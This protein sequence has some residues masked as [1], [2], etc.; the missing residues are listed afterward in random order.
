MCQYIHHF[1]RWEQQF[2]HWVGPSGIIFTFMLCMNIPQSMTSTHEKSIASGSWKYNHDTDPNKIH[3]PSLSS[4]PLPFPF[5]LPPPMKNLVCSQVENAGTGMCDDMGRSYSLKVHAFKG[6]GGW[7]G[8][9]IT[10][11]PTEN[12]TIKSTGLLC[13]SPTHEFIWREKWSHFTVTARRVYYHANPPNTWVLLHLWIL[14]HYTTIVASP[15]YL[16]TLT[17]IFC[18]NKFNHLPNR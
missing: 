17:T 7:G 2:L 12:A 1:V 10:K 5:P 15:T 9:C 6:K 13:T 16:I 8:T 3:N 4:L 11:S 14:F 18:V